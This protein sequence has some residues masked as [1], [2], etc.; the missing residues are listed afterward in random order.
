MNMPMT[1]PRTRVFWSEPV[2][3]LKF[4]RAN[5]DYAGNFSGAIPYEPDFFRP[6]LSCAKNIFGPI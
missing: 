1:R 6:D 5:R 2:C 4:S 3:S